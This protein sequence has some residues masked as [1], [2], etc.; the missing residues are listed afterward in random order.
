[1][2]KTNFSIGSRW[3]TVVTFATAMAWVESAVVYYLRTMIDRIEPYQPNPLPIIGGLGPAE[4]VREAATMVMLL[5]VGILAGRNWRSRLGFSAIAFGVWDIFY[6][7]FLKLMCGWPHSLF[8]WDILFLLPLPWWGP[9]LAPV[10]IALLMILWGTLV[11]SWRIERARD[12][13]EW[14]VW[15]LNFLGV[16]LALYMFMADSLRVADGGVDALRKVLPQWFNWPLFCLA[17]LL[18][19]APILQVLWE[20]VGRRKNA[21]TLN[22]ERWINHFLRNRENRIEPEWSMPI[23]I[24][25]HD[26]ESLLK[27]L[28]QFQLGDGGGP[29]SL[30]ARDAERFRSSTR[31]MR[32]LV[33]LWFAEER[34]HSRLLGCA[35]D[36]LGGTRIKSHWSFTAFCQCRRVFGVRFELQV[37]LLTEITSTCYYRLLQRH[38]KIPALED[39]C[40]LILRDEAGHVSFHR[41]RLIAAGRSRRGIR[42]ILWSAQFQLCGYAAA[43][44]LWL[45]HKQCLVGLGATTEE[46]YREVGREVNRFLR[47]LL[48]RGEVPI[49]PKGGIAEPRSLAMAE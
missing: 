17:L 16:G 21:K 19:A 26:M 5:T 13:S 9:V 33:D 28:A 40:H 1:M 37:L 14:K 20:M 2:K 29:A 48:V 43:T 11:S 10:S 30:I 34:E 32:R 35:V 24:L 8:D 6:Y 41:D 38:C 47:S 15:G 39:M 25:P 7:V 31:Q 45:N 49:S 23:R 46:F 44:M 42:S 18:M 27:S 3:L 22:Y 4:M 36:S 12:G